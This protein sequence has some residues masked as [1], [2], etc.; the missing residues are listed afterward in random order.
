MRVFEQGI[1]HLE[2]NKHLDWYSDDPKMQEECKDVCLDCPIMVQ[3]AQH[4]LNEQEI[5]G[6]WGGMDEFRVRRAI[7][8]DNFGDVRKRVYKQRCPFCNSNDLTYSTKKE[9]EQYSVDCENCGVCWQAYIV[10][11]KV[12]RSLKRKYG[13]D[14]GKTV[15]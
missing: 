3:C 11:A 14:M 1:C 7:A 4:A 8:V 13:P 10:P 6:I 5:W 9:D 2:E 15:V 12:E